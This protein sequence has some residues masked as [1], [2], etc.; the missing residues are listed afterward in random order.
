MQTYN[1]MPSMTAEMTKTTVTEI[2][3]Q[4]GTKSEFHG[5]N[6]FRVT[7]PIIRG[8]Y[9]PLVGRC[10]APKIP[11]QGR[12]S[13][14]RT[15]FRWDLSEVGVVAMSNGFC[16]MLPTF[17]LS[18]VST[19][20]PGAVSGRRIRE[21]G[22]TPH[23]QDRHGAMAME[24]ERIHHRKMSSAHSH[25]PAPFSGNG[26]HARSTT[27]PECQPQVAPSRTDH[28]LSLRNNTLR[29]YTTF[30]Q[31]ISSKMDS[32]STQSGANAGSKGPSFYG[33]PHF[34]SS[35]ASARLIRWNPFLL[36]M[37]TGSFS[38]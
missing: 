12:P 13:P 16:T 30:Y 25:A 38:S 20:S 26:G 31:E 24:T 11:H 32:V 10:W 34:Y 29:L 3:N 27:N 19:E 14:V 28:G 18:N 1:S 36:E 33:N 23:P 6:D 5:G 7:I 37:S 9:S 35:F 2:R 8:T 17:L 22:K 21:G 4:R 15:P